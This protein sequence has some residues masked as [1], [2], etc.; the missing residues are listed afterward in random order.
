MERVVQRRFYLLH[1]FMERF[2]QRR[3]FTYYILL[4]KE[5]YSDVSLRS[6]FSYGVSRITFSY[7]VICTATSLYVL[8]SLMERVAGLPADNKKK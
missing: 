6:T 7:G 8:H 1:S 3:L 4:W 5:L 2:V